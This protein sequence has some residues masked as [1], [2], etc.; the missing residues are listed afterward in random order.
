[1]GKKEHARGG[2][3]PLQPAH[4]GETA[5][6]RDVTVLLP[7]CLLNTLRLASGPAEISSVLRFFWK[8]LIWWLARSSGAN[9]DKTLRVTGVTHVLGLGSGELF[10]PQEIYCERYTSDWPT[11]SHKPAGS[12]LMSE[13]TLAYTR[14]SKRRRGR[15]STPLNQ[16]RTVIAA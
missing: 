6:A 2:C 9:E 3:R 14:S 12:S 10:I 15:M 8:A 13:Q 7:R 4:G 11:S 16:I 1:M 5:S